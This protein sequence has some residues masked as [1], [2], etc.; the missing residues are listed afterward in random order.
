VDPRAVL[1]LNLKL[2][3]GTKLHVG[4]RKS[5]QSLPEWGGRGQEFIACNTA[6][7]N[8]SAGERELFRTAGERQQPSHQLGGIIW[9]PHKQ[10]TS[11]TPVFPL[12]LLP[13]HPHFPL[14]DVQIEPSPQST[15]GEQTAA[16]HKQFLEAASVSVLVREL[17]AC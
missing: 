15:S 3:P 9:E 16:Q 5:S 11:V 4:R 6:H 1:L 2:G 14:L 12:P 10:N 17:Y 7:P 13:Q 8:R